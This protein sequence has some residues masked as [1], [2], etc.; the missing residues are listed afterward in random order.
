[1]TINEMESFLVRRFVSA[2]GLHGRALLRTRT[3]K[4][5]RQQAVKSLLASIKMIRTKRLNKPQAM[6]RPGFKDGLQDSIRIEGLVW[7][8]NYDRF[9]RC[10]LPCSILLGTI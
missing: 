4:V 2:A 9:R 6:F 8:P 1:M 10:E 7:L 5:I 3:P